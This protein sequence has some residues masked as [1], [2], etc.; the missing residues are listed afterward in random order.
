MT[1][2]FLPST[3]VPKGKAWDC[4]PKTNAKLRFAFVFGVFILLA[5]IQWPLRPAAAHAELLAADPPP[6]AV[7]AASPAEVRLT[8]SE[9]LR[10]GSTFVVFGEG[11]AQVPGFSPAI[12]TESP[13]QLVAAI[14]A[15]APGAYTVQWTAVTGD[16]HEVSGSYSF[17]VEIEEE[18][19]GGA[20]LWWVLGVGAVGLLVLVLYRRVRRG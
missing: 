18:G 13:E 16:G 2:A 10:A 17:G 3:R 9:A 4:S 7:L 15:L 1:S 20:G 19:R 14:P 8:F 12:V 5:Q 6:G 11:F